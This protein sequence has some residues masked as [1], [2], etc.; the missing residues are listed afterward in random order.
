M[1]G[2]NVEIVVGESVRRD[3]KPSSSS[4]MTGC[5]RENPGNYWHYSHGGNNCDDIL[6]H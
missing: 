3:K 1:N 5:V 4:F 2:K 6:L